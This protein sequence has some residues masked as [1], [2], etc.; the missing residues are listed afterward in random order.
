MLKQ[1][2]LQKIRYSKIDER[3]GVQFT[4]R[5][6]IPTFVPQPNI[7]AIDVTDLDEGKQLEVQALLTEYSEYVK[8]FQKT[9][10]KFEDWVQHTKDVYI[11]PKWRT[12][13]TANT[14][15]L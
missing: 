11:E 4:E 15:I 8:D 6:I 10:F 13:K 14:K 2:E 9:M 1:H 7:K 5:D 12:F 3:V